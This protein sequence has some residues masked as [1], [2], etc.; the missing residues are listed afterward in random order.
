MNRGTSRREIEHNHTDIKKVRTLG[1][2]R[3]RLINVKV[4]VRN[5]QNP[6]KLP[7]CVNYYVRYRLF[8]SCALVFPHHSKRKLFGLKTDALVVGQLSCVVFIFLIFLFRYTGSYA[9]NGH[10][11]PLL[12]LLLPLYSEQTTTWPSGVQVDAEKASMEYYCPTWKWICFG[13]SV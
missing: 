11:K 13:G 1:Y 6:S 12:N 8:F 9:E 7:M 2:Y 5:L 4:Q 10:T 3:Q